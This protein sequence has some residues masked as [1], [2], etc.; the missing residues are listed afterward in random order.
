MCVGIVVGWYL[1]V[2][3]DWFY[4]QSTGG[5]Q[6]CGARLVSMMRIT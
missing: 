3:G 5:I 6:Q 1:L 2:G 4:G